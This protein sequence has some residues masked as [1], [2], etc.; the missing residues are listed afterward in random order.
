MT[1]EQAMILAG[2]E[3][4]K[5]LTHQQIVEFQLFEDL[6]CMPFNVFHEAV[7]KCLGRP[8]LTSEFARIET[9]KREFRR[10][11]TLKREFQRIACNE[12]ANLPSASDTFQDGRID[13][14]KVGQDREPND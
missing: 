11:E 14:G 3:F 1:K 4:W 8:V 6:L 5:K 10:I 2:T 9:L 12:I 13:A 7:E